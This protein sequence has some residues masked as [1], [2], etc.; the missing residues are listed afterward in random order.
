MRSTAPLR[1]PPAASVFA[2]VF[3]Q[4]VCSG[5]PIGC[6]P[7]DAGVLTRPLTAGSHKLEFI[8]YQ[9]GNGAD[10][11]S[12]PFGLLY[13]GTAPAVPEPATMFLAG[14]A[15][16]AIGLARRRHPKRS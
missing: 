14:G 1:V 15:L 10:N 7:Q 3:S 5:F 9:V 2:P 13:S 4:N 16:L 6:R 12:N 11:V 8:L